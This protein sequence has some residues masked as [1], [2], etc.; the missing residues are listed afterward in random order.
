MKNTIKLKSVTKSDLLFLYKIL[1]EREPI[2]NISHKKM[3]TWKQHVKFVMSKPYSK[4]YIIKCDGKSVGSVYLSKQDEIGVFIKKEMQKKK[5]GKRALRLLIKSNPR[6]R[7]LANVNPKNTKSIRFFE[8]NGFKL[9]QYTYEL[10]KK[11]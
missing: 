7:Y 6:S 8:N 10:S 5:I 11:N 2:V 9:I 1:S 3:P 4:W